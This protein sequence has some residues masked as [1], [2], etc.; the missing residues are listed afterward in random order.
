MVMLSFSSDMTVS[1]IDPNTLHELALE[2]D[3]R[4][5]ERLAIELGLREDEIK[6]LK[7]PH[8]GRCFAA[9]EFIHNLITLY[10]RE[11]LV[12]LRQKVIEIKRNDV[13]DFIDSS[14][15]EL[16]MSHLQD[17]PYQL[18]EEL[19]SRLEQSQFNSIKCWRHIAGLYGYDNQFINAIQSAEYSNYPHSPTTALIEYVGTRQPAL[20]LSEIGTILE[21]LGLIR[22]SQKLH[23][24]CLNK[25]LYRSLPN[26]VRIDFI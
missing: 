22:M 21:R 19:A 2:L 5:W 16:M 14:L 24:L 18:K 23:E 20:G 26:L 12:D 17:I 6:Q 1:H 11:R 15:S 7:A 10:P 8:N 13:A 9:L 25:L 3:P 4:N